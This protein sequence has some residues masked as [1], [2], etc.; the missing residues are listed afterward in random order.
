MTNGLKTLIV[1]SPFVL[2][3]KNRVHKLFLYVLYF[4]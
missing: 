4:H 2:R 1:N 3:K